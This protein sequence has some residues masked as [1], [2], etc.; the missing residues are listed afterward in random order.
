MAEH[1][2]K[3]LSMPKAGC[4]STGGPL[5]SERYP[6]LNGR[7]R[8]DGTNG[9]RDS[10]KDAQTR[11]EDVAGVTSK[12]NHC[13]HDTSV[14]EHEPG[15]R[16]IL[17]A[18]LDSSTDPEL[19]AVKL[20]IQH[21]VDFFGVPT[22]HPHPGSTGLLDRNNI[23][24]VGIGF[25]RIR[26]RLTNKLCVVVGVTR[27]AQMNDV[28]ASV[29]I[30]GHIWW[31]GQTYST[32]VVEVTPVGVNFGL[33]QGPQPPPQPACTAG[34]K[35]FARPV[36]CGVSTSNYLDGTNTAGT[37]GCR[38][39]LNNV[40]TTMCILSCNHV[41]G[42][43]N[44]AAVGSSVLQPGKGDLGKH[45]ADQIGALKDLV[46]LK[47]QPSINYVDMAVA[48]TNSNL[49]SPQLNCIGAI[50]GAYINPSVGMLLRKV[51]KMTNYTHAARID[52]IATSVIIDFGIG[53]LKFEGIS[54]VDN[55]PTFVMPGDS[56][57]I[58][59]KES[60]TSPVGMMIA[61]SGVVG[62]LVPM[63]TMFS[64]PFFYSGVKLL[65]IVSQ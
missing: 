23:Q 18:S 16:E 39:K 50:S 4:S 57:S 10:I 59:L 27:K 65:Q 33:L 11:S 20:L 53:P 2:F 22:M 17:L 31:R 24:S 7:T 46:K 3:Q 42:R 45:P 58:A 61:G 43:E 8:N 19:I 9:E 35:R 6:Q 55:T 52:T 26:G 5:T 32:D 1:R 40:G 63:S 15:Q 36:P 34:T 12:R 29:R 64:T 60:T 13:A 44:A 48:S 49:T 25:K 37:I 38:V 51:G 56:G 54:R 14:P 47:L 30:P 21:Q 28:E 62:I 41:L